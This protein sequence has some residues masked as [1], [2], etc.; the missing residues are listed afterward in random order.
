MPSVTVTW[1][2]AR[3]DG[4]AVGSLWPVRVLDG[5]GKGEL[6]VGDGECAEGEMRGLRLEVGACLR[7][8]CGEFGGRRGDGEF[9]VMRDEQILHEEVGAGER[10]TADAF[11][12]L[13]AE[14]CV[15]RRTCDGGHVA[16]LAGLLVV[17]V[18]VQP[19]EVWHLLGEAAAVFQR[20]RAWECK[21]Y[22]MI[23]RGQPGGDDR[24]G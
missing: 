1:S 19:L 17:V 4:Y 16:G 13:A 7:R 24:T 21:G 2:Q 3:R 11:A 5:D 22:G 18:A 10:V 8:G 6:A 15:W 20:R 14:S 9:V 23:R 12:G